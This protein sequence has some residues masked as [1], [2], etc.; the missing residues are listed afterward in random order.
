MKV[1]SY[2]HN[3]GKSVLAEKG[4]LNDVRQ[5]PEVWADHPEQKQHS[6]RT[7]ALS[8][9]GGW[10]TE[11]P[12]DMGPASEPYH[13][14]LTPLFDAYHRSGHVAVEHEKKEQMRARWHMQKM[15]VGHR[16]PETLPVD[17]GVMVYPAGEDASLRRTRRELTGPFF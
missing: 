13:E 8:E 6:A 2:S 16:D 15:E 9:L 10:E 4:L 7:A 11:V 12:I 1:E 17:V 3:D 14:R 5:M